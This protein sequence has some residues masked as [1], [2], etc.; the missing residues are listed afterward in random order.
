MMNVLC[1]HEMRKQG[2]NETVLNKEL[3]KNTQISQLETGM[4]YS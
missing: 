4:I 1:A 3:M 2:K